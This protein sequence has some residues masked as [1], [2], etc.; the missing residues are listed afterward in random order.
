MSPLLPTGSRGSANDPAAADL[1]AAEGASAAK[2]EWLSRPAT[3]PEYTS[4][5]E[6]LETHFAWVFL[7][8]TRAYKLKKPIRTYGADLRTLAERERCC[9]EE[10]RLNR[11]LAAETY[12]DVVPIVAG[13]HGLALGGPGAVVDWLV[14]MRRLEAAQMLEV[15]LCQGRVCAADLAAI[16]S[17]LQR[18]DTG[19]RGVAAE[20]LLH[21][22]AGRLD[23]AIREIARSE[24]A[25][26][27]TVLEPLTAHLRAEFMA[28]RPVLESRAGRVREGHGD[29]R[30][31]HVWLGS[32]LQ[33]IDALEFSVDLRMLDPAE[34]LAMLAVDLLRLGAAWA[35]A[36]LYEAYVRITGD[37]LPARLWRFFRTLRALTRAKV[38]FWHLDDPSQASAA[39]H[40]RERGRAWLALAAQL[41]AEPEQ[42]FSPA[43]PPAR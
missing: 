7:T 4:G 19:P 40:W 3:Y 24:F 31:E 10:L 2:I 36:A 27:G 38:A 33:V 8:D 18:L 30:A 26:P 12:F 23:E 29:L 15:R 5:V 9:R 6:R 34:D 32:P 13:E 39:E 41:L 16:V 43:G 37:A 14:A 22:I 42:A 20:T 21:G 17:H 25:L 28:L 1:F 35:D 11:R